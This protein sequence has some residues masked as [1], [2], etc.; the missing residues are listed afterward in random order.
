MS[1][2]LRSTTLVLISQMLLIALTFAWLLQMLIIAREGSAY[3]I[4][5]NKL[6][7]WGEVAVI[8]IIF[9]FALYVLV[10]QIRRLGERRADDRRN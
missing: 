7:L 2:R 5:N 10:I 8:A 3:F 4:E 6:I 1:R 9:V